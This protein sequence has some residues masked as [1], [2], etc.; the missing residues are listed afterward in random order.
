MSGRSPPGSC[1]RRFSVAAVSNQLL[2]ISPPPMRIIIDA[3][4][5]ISPYPPANNIGLGLDLLS[6]DDDPRRQSV[7]NENITKLMR[8]I[9]PESSPESEP[10]QGSFLNVVESSMKQRRHSDV[11]MNMPKVFPATSSTVEDRGCASTASSRAPSPLITRARSSSNLINSCSSRRHSS[12]N[13]HDIQRFATKM[14]NRAGEAMNDKIE[15][16]SKVSDKFELCKL[17]YCYRR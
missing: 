12:I 13:P 11:A 4:S 10:E 7:S 9:S 5:P 6:M 16:A 14:A 17:I 1:G 8:A 15:Q 3:P 2:T